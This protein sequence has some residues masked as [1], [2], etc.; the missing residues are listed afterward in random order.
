MKKILFKK[1]LLDYLTFFLIALLAST[2]II[3]VFQ[4]VNFLDIMI[5]DGRNYLVYVNYTLLNFPKIFSKLFPFVLF[6]SLFYVTTRYEFSNEL[7]IL[8]N[9]GIN[10][11]Q[12]INF[13]L[14]ISF[15]LMFVQIILT[16]IIVP[17]SQDKARSF[18]RTSK[19]NFFENFIKP[20]RFNDTI[21]NVTIYSERKD[22][23]GNL[24]NLYIK[25]EVNKNN[26]QITYAKKGVFKE[27]KGSPV[28]VLF[29]GET[30]TQ[31]NNKFTN[32]GFSK[33]DFSLQNMVSN[34]ITVTKTQEIPTVDLLIC[35]NFLYDL[36]FTNKK[37]DIKNCNNNNIKNILKEFYKRLVIPLYIPTLTL[38]SFLL[39]LKSKENIDFFKM[40]IMTFII[41]LLF[42][43]LSETTIRLI[44]K[45]LP[46][47]I[48]IM[49]I[50]FLSFV[51]LYFFFLYKFI[52]SIKK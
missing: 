1:L 43:I 5:E 39:I 36:K 27:T 13:I 41:G 18:L 34:T 19:V 45:N 15:F 4:A 30:I 21:S 40:R 44:S 24:Y 29:E 16:S 49:S 31:K 26:L 38:I 52:L 14:L 48:M 25:K 12:I 32:L 37:I 23:E 6:F 2:I 42:I 20:Q 35:I 3:W 17:S 51:I 47:N 46:E 8:W 50:P 28:L 10:K 9:Y 7:I 33:S 11:I 22:N